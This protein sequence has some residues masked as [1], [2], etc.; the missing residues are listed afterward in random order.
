[1]KRIIVLMIVFGMFIFI[2][3]TLTY[4]AESSDGVVVEAPTEA[5]AGEEVPKEAQSPETPVKEDAKEEPALAHEAPDAAAPDKAS[6]KA[7]Y[8]RSAEDNDPADDLIEKAVKRFNAGN[9]YIYDL[10]I[11]ESK[12]DELASCIASDHD[13]V[14]VVITI[15]DGYAEE[16]LLVYD[17]CDCGCEATEKP[18]ETVARPGATP[19]EEGSWEASFTEEEPVVVPE[20]TEDSY[21]ERET[22][23]P[24]EE[25]AP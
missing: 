1:M 13:G 4:A 5:P 25:E 9:S 23:A 24:E 6:A 11:P 21:A 15:T 22:E 8:T 16:I 14:T 17:D 12:T 18:A 7:E 19:L 10:R 3:P 20:A 2:A